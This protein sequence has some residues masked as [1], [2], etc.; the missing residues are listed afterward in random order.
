MRTEIKI[1][2][3]RF[4][5]AGTARPKQVQGEQASTRDGRPVWTVRLTAIEAE[6]NTAETIW[7]EVPGDQP[8]LTID[9]LVIPVCLVYTPRVNRKGEIVR[10]FRAE[11]IT[12]DPSARKTA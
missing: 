8:D 4:R 9:D 1:D 2:G 5:V 10:A 6:R 12:P 7:V 11:A 3:T